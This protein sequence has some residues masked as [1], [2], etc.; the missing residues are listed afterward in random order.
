MS[1]IAL[2]DAGD[3]RR[4]VL[5]WAS[6]GIAGAWT[7]WLTV[8]TR[9]WDRTTLWLD[10]FVCCWLISVSALVVFDGEVVSG[11]AFFATGYP[12]SAALAWAVRYGPRGGL[13]A[14][15]ILSGFLVL[16]RP[17]NAVPLNDLSGGEIRDIAGGVVNYLLAGGAVG[18]VSL[19]LIRS[20]EA[21]E[22]ATAA[23]VL[24]RE[25]AARLAERESLARQIH[26][27]VLQ[28]LALIHKR[29]RELA[30]RSPIPPDEVASLS[31]LAGRE[32]VELR[33]LILR[34][35]D[36]VPEGR[37]SLRAEIESLAR[38]FEEID[39]TVS[40]VG[41]VWCQRADGLELTAAV[42]QGLT[43]VEKHAR[44]SQATVFVEEDERGI[45]L[46]I[47][48]DGAGFV[49]DEDELRAAGKAGLLKSMKGRVEDL[50]GTMT[51]TTAPGKGTEIEFVVPTGDPATSGTNGSDTR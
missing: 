7:L 51:V 49:Y 35:P 42:R 27:S 21:L 24:E 50:G 23:L 14:G 22:A 25:R 29:G 15:G 18:I 33:G 3:L 43:N 10:L 26:D 45:A 6:I 44:A 16:T 2:T 41:P 17:L 28:A 47:R 5:A 36:D 37:I 32:E 4:P 48:D 31:E 34:E 12:V 11:R 39:V 38:S 13:L 20:S 40:S 46:S 19:L 9:G 30:S 1:I 8:P